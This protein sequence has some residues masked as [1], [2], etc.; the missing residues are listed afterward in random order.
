MK[1]DTHNRTIDKCELATDLIL[2]GLSYVNSGFILSPCE[3][4]DLLGIKPTHPAWHQHRTVGML[5]KML[6][7]HELQ[8]EVSPSSGL[9]VT[10]TRACRNE[11]QPI[12]IWV[13]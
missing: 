5:L 2:K 9:T 8:V 7:R 10:Q 6:G 1:A 13:H 3:V 11:F 12:T 4:R